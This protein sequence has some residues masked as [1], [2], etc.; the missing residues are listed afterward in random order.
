MISFPAS[1]GRYNR[2]KTVVSK[3]E[4]E[5]AVAWWYIP[6]SGGGHPASL[7]VWPLLFHFR[8]GYTL[9]PALRKLR[10]DLR[11]VDMA[12]YMTMASESLETPWTCAAVHDKSRAADWVVLNR[13]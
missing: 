2:G 11:T 13:D 5:I 8:M 6:A 1:S 12:G 7:L 3:T 4:V 10:S 9:M